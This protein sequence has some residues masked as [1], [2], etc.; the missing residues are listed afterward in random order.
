MT[1]W[2]QWTF[3]PPDQM[4][5]IVG[6]ASGE[7]AFNHIVALGGIPGTGS[8]PSTPGRSGKRNTSSTG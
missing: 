7:T 6:E 5:L 2:F 8:P 3:L 4:D 1:P